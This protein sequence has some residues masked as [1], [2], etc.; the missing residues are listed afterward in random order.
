MFLPQVSFHLSSPRLVEWR[1]QGPCNALDSSSCNVAKDG[2]G[3][4]V[5]L[6]LLARADARYCPAGVTPPMA[7]AESCVELSEPS[8]PGMRPEARPLRTRRTRH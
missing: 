1:A 2:V 4:A 3:I 5:R 7:R 6:G 8:L